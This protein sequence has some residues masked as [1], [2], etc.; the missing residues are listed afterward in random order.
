MAAPVQPPSADVLLAQQLAAVESQKKE[1]SLLQAWRGT[2]PDGSSV[3]IP[4]DNKTSATAATNVSSPSSPAL[5]ASLLSYQAGPRSAVKIRPR[6]FTPS[7]KTAAAAAGSI[8]RGSTNNSAR[9]PLLSPDSFLGSS[10]KKL[11]IKP[12]SLTP[13]PKLRLLLQNG[14]KSSPNNLQYQ[15]QQNDKNI[16]VSPMPTQI[17]NNVLQK[18]NQSIMLE[19]TLLNG[20]SP[21]FVSPDA[22]QTKKQ[23]ANEN[24]Q[25]NDANRQLALHSTNTT[26]DED[27]SP[28]KSSE[29]I[30]YDFYQ[31]V[32]RSPAEGKTEFRTD[33]LPKL[34]KEGYQIFPTMEDIQKLSESELKSVSQFEIRRDGIGSIVWDGAVDVRGLDLDNIVSIEPKDVAVYDAAEIAGTKPPVGS[35]LNCPEIITL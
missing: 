19:N 25:N 2:P 9:S 3:V 32:I 10:A 18:E 35:K 22:N 1:L 4:I 30:A 14:N 8:G 34:T 26:N 24:I 23:I 20:A 27:S 13:K 15:N 7:S 28:N 29:G 16:D 6:A 11:V 33:S 12:G 17:T 5:M 21:P 31:K